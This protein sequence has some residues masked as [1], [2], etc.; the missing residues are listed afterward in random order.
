[1]FSKILKKQQKPEA[2]IQLVCLHHAVGSAAMYLNWQ[3]KLPEYVEVSAVQLPGRGNLLNLTSFDDIK[4][5]AADVVTLL[6]NEV[7]K[8]YVIFGHS[9]GALLGFEVIR[10]LQQNH[11]KKLL[12]FV[13]SGLSAPHIFTPKIRRDL[14]N[15]KELIDLLAAYDKDRVKQDQAYFELLRLI[16]PTARNDFKMH[17]NYRFQ[18]QPDILSCP[19]IAIA[20]KQDN[21]HSID[22][23]LLWRELTNADFSSKIFPG[24]HMFLFDELDD[25]LD[26][27]GNELNLI[28]AKNKL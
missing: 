24:G 4:A 18:K 21:E 26:W 5:A 3:S 23:I 8:P 10:H 2:K 17:D 19:I 14:M 20:G 25:F 11:Q 15:D 28:V 16:L 13:A 6:E 7:E 9:L 1:M 27:F 22:N 12:A